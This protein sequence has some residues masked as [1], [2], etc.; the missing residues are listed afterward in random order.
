MKQEHQH[1]DKILPF[2]ELIRGFANQSYISKT[3]LKNFLRI[4]GIYFNNSEKENLVPC[5]ST[6]LLSPSEF[7]ILRDYQNT[8]EDNTKK[9]TSRLEW[10]TNKTISETLD[11]FSFENLIPN[12]GVNF[13]FNSEPQI[14][15]LDNN[16]NKILINYEIERNDLNKSWYESTNIFKGKIEIEKVSENEIKITKSYTSSESNLVGDNLQ[17]SLLIH[18]KNNNFVQKDKELIKILFGDFSNE[19]RI[20]FFYRL[21][22]NMSSDYFEFKDIINTEFRPDPSISLPDEIDWMNNKSE[23]KLK[24]NQIHNTFFIRKKKYHKNLQ[25]WEIES[26]FDFEYS[27]YKGSCNVIFSF[28]DFLN[29]ED[30]SEFEIAISNFSLHDS[31]DYTPKEKT[32]IKNKILDLF[33]QKKD[34]T[35]KNFIEYLKGEK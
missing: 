3:D 7:D 10:N 27:N 19:D 23:L 32:E 12:E 11:N 15:I 21:S 26:S 31:T 20:V 18:F 5:L 35:Y 8:R 1:I 9:N 28:Q 25:F 30:K 6:L 24:G 34:E 33:E 17:K 14:S 13:W 4:R 16:P 2:G 29:S 22:S